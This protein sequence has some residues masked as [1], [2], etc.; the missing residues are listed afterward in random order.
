VA[1][2]VGVLVVV[3]VDVGVWVAAA[4]PAWMMRGRK[5]CGVE[6]MAGMAVSGALAMRMMPAVMKTAVITI[7]VETAVCQPFLPIISNL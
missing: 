7:M 2:A 4:V 6:A 1:V 3:A 5:V